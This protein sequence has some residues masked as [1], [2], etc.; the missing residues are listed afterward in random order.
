MNFHL[1]LKLKAFAATKR[2]AQLHYH[3]WK[4]ARKTTAK[5]LSIGR[6]LE[7]LNWETHFH[8]KTHHK[9][10]HTKTESRNQQKRV[11]VILLA[12]NNNN[13]QK[14]H[15]SSIQHWSHTTVFKVPG[16]K[17]ITEELGN[18][19]QNY[20]PQSTTFTSTHL[21]N[22]NSSFKVPGLK[23]IS[24]ELGNYFHGIKQSRFPSLGRIL[25]A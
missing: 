20:P 7:A 6:M 9:L 23:S 1:L 5:F 10:L 11:C 17:W 15:V 24:Q 21:N 18:Y 22:H 19:V 3:V 13:P 16:E 14:T 12:S 25:E 2:A 4:K 8:F